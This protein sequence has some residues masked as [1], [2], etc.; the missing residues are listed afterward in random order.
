MAEDNL[1]SSSQ[2]V[3]EEVGWYVLT[4][5]QETLGP[6]AS[7]ELQ[8]H[9]QNGY[10]S[11]QTLL[12]SQGRNNWTPLSSIPDLFSTIS[13]ATISQP[14]SETDDPDANQLEQLTE[15]LNGDGDADDRPSTPPDGE[16]EFTDDD[17]THYKWDSRLRAWVPQDSI[18]SDSGSY[19]VEEMVFVKEEEVFPTLKLAENTL[20]EEEELNGSSDVEPDSK[21]APKRK[22]PDKQ[23]REKKE[24]NKPP[25]SWFKLIVNTNVYVKGLPE[26]VT[27]EELVE[28]FSKCGVIKE[29]VDTRKPRVK[30]YVDEE[31][32]KNKGDALISYLKEPSVD[33]AIKI[34]DG[35]PLRP[36]GKIVMLVERAEFKQKGDKFKP[37]QTD[38]KKKKKLKKAE[39]R[40]LGWGGRDD[41]K[42]LTPATVV[43]RHMFS[44]AEMRADENLELE[45]EEDVKEE[46]EKLG[47]VDAIKVCENHPQGVVLAKFKD[48]KDAQ[49]CIDLMNGRWFGGRKVHASLDDGSVNHAAVKDEEYEAARLEEFGAELEAA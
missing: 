49:K 31:T 6:Y 5:N 43:L 24:A 7:Q 18:V 32:G 37:K 8:V 12:W 26:D 25:D 17:G 39:D 46:C 36:G 34:L 11:G 20:E 19:K 38:N 9:F 16:M 14:H 44:P 30:I 15:A 35:T 28:V 1:D 10:I 45:L 21:P 29:D 42:V 23:Q 27:V 2:L 13:H 4:H 33:L 47:P 41:A 22:K 3:E 40:R 48:I